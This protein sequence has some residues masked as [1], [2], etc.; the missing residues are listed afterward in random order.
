M[1]ESAA[2]RTTE[3]IRDLTP[4]QLIG[5]KLATV[6]PPLWEIGHIGWFHEYFILRRLYG[7]PPLLARGDELYDSIAIEHERRWDLPIYDRERTLAYLDEVRER[8][9]GRLGEG[10]ATAEDSFIYQF[11]VFHQDMHNEA[12]LWARQTHGLPAPAFEGAGP[13]PL[14]GGG[15]LPGDAEIPGGLFELGASGD[16]RF[17]FDNEKYAHPV[18][19]APFELARA[20]VTNAEF[21]AFVADGGYRRSELWREDGWAWRSGCAAEHPINWRAD[22]PRGWRVRHFDRW[23]DLSPHQPVIHVNWYEADAYCRW[24]A[25]RLPTEAEWEFAATRG[26]G[27]PSDQSDYPWGDAAP[28][29]GHANLDGFALGCADVAACPDGDNRFGCRQLIGNVWEWTADTFAPYPGFAPD[30]YREYSEPLFGR[31]KVLRG[32]AWPTRT[33]MITARYR[34]YFEP[35]RRDVFAGFRTCAV[36]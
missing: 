26:L 3:L 35:H 29:P 15:P 33:R 8:L 32:G 20:P 27:D 11:T 19:V 34:N 30:A 22:G 36:G 2:R 21:A 14:T 28:T 5:P 31:T 1:L 13:L 6:N 18:S 4:E 25:R 9:A 12:L 23:Q 16:D 17:G 24:A 10:L 7:Y